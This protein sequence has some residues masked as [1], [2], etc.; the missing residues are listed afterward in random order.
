MIEGREGKGQ[1]GILGRGGDIGDIDGMRG[2]G[3][4]RRGRKCAE[5]I[6]SQ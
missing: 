4:V 1:G 6:I 2:K 3:I 5:K